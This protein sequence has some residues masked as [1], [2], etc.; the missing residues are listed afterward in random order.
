[1]YSYGNIPYICTM[2]ANEL[3]AIVEYL[4]ESYIENVDANFKYVKKEKDI[5]VQVKDGVG[6]SY[7]IIIWYNSLISAAGCPHQS[8][9]F[10]T[11]D[12]SEKLTMLETYV[13]EACERISKEELIDLRKD[14]PTIG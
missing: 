12:D 4:I 8:K 6:T 5:F 1:M 14:D 10:F 9:E 11:W 3:K 13:N 2:K 7:L